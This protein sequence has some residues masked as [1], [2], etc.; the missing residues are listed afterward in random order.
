[1][2]SAPTTDAGAWK[3]ALEAADGVSV[4]G[5]AS[6]ICSEV[7]E[8]AIAPFGNDLAVQFLVGG[9]KPAAKASGELR[10]RW[11]RR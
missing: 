9:I 10:P 4:S 2:P 1:M 11:G 5:D 3:Q 8:T 6:V 7:A